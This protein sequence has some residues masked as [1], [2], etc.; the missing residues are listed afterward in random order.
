MLDPD[1]ARA[2][3]LDP[4]GGAA[5]AAPVFLVDR[6]RDGRRKVI[7]PSGIDH[8]IDIDRG[9]AR[10]ALQRAMKMR[11]E[12]R[13]AAEAGQEIS[14]QRD[15]RC[16]ARCRRQRGFSEARPTAFEIKHSAPCQHKRS[17]CVSPNKPADF[18]QVEASR[19]KA[20]ARSTSV[21]LRPGSPPFPRA[22]ISITL[23][24]AR[25]SRAPA[26]TSIEARG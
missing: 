3:G 4:G 8:R 23:R 21:I 26:I 10:K 24:H 6:H 19:R 13:N 5:I 9:M 16:A 11:R 18:G 22:D 1:E 25:G 14:D 2:A 12:G 15:F 20:G 17:S 7:A